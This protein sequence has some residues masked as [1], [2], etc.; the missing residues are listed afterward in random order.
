MRRSFAGFLASNKITTPEYRQVLVYRFTLK[1]TSIKHTGFQIFT[2]FEQSLSNSES[3]QF[4]DN[5]TWFGRFRLPDT[6]TSINFL[7]IQIKIYSSCDIQDYIISILVVFLGYTRYT[8][9]VPTAVL[10]CCFS[11]L[12]L[13]FSSVSNLICS[14]NPEITPSTISLTVFF[15]FCPRAVHL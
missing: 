5:V 8:Y 7:D 13:A 12:R 14:D 4:Y 10:F 9:T 1:P 2:V 3:G 6:V 15:F 11:F